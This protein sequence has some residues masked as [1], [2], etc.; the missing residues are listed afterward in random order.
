MSTSGNRCNDGR[1]V[2]RSSVKTIGFMLLLLMVFWASAPAFAADMILYSGRKE[3]AIKPVVNAF[4][5]Q[6]GITVALKTGK[7]SGLANTLILEQRRPRA[8]VFI[9]TVGGVMEILANKGVLSSYRSPAAERLPAEFKS[10]S[11]YWT[12]ISGRARIIIYNTELVAQNDVPKSVFEL[13]DPQ[14]EGKVAVAGTRERT[15]LS[16]ASW[17]VHEKGKDSIQQYFQQLRS[18][19]LTI[20]SDNSEVWRG[21]GRGEF[22]IGVT[23]SPNSHLAVRAGLPV[24]EV[25][26]DQ[27]T[28]GTLVNLNTIAVV[29]GGPHLEP[30]KQFVDFVLSP[31]GQR[32]LVE[33]AYE[34]PLV[35]DVDSGSVKPLSAMK[36]PSVTVRSLAAAAD[37]TMDL[38]RAIDPR[39]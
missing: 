8:D 30:A 18:N 38:L 1:H 33:K 20:L 12:G 32:L 16:W 2:V 6:T 29:E 15:T 10:E 11:G 24:G 36:T 7:T 37:S 25:Y 4:T 22:A 21:V 23:N 13:V 5:A 27:N 31:I 19:G 9:A 39:W 35:P 3:K 34:I 26:P 17:L 14:W 28:I